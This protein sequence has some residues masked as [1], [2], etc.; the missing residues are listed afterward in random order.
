MICTRKKS[1][2]WSTALLILIALFYDILGTKE[3]LLDSISSTS[4]SVAFLANQNSTNTPPRFFYH[5]EPDHF[6]HEFVRCMFQL[7]HCHILY[8]HIQKT[9]GSFIASRIYPGQTQKHYDSREWCCNSKFMEGEFNKHVPKYC[10]MNMGV[11]EV[12]P[13]QFKQVIRAC[14]EY[15][16]QLK[17]KDDRMQHR[18]IGLLSVREPIQRSLSGIHQRCN[19][20]SSQLDKATR[21]ICERCA[22]VDEDEAF[23]NK[24]VNNTNDMYNGM[25]REILADPSIDIPLF[26]IDSTHINDFFGKIE[27]I[28]TSRL[29]KAGK[30]TSNVTF[31][32]PEGKPNAEKL[33]KICDFGM[34]STLMKNHLPALKAYHWIWAQKTTL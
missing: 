32:L 14:Q 6:A 11:Y 16:P 20:H 3:A 31:K 21:A 18:Y 9:G 4:Y 30:I 24:I 15:L 17:K 33:E 10:S 28:V 7:D 19:V 12:K 27:S 25:Q 1:L 26:T 23:Y 22:Y 34:P 8:W 29:M 5:D 13:H 2:L